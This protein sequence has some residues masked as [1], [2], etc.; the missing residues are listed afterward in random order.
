MR[1]KP[2]DPRLH[3]IEVTSK[4]I[5]AIQIAAMLFF[6]AYVALLNG[7]SISPLYIPL[8]NV[9]L[10]GS[11]LLLLVSAERLFFFRVSMRYTKRENPKFIFS[12]KSLSGSVSLIIVSVLLLALILLPYTSEL[13]MNGTAAGSPAIVQF[14]GSALF[15][16]A[17]ADTITVRNDGAGSLNFA[18][19]TPSSYQ[20]ATSSDGMNETVIMASSLLG[21]TPALQPGASY[22]FSVFLNPEDTYY[23]IFL[24]STGPAQAQYTI[25]YADNVTDMIAA[26]VVVAS[27]II[28]AFSASAA[29]KSMKELRGSTIYT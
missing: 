7:F 20:A 6:A 29:R 17:L 3:R 1:R 28:L 8:D 23:L 19:V 22:S 16:V 4:A 10:V 27:V 5:F 26:G 12:K 18:L 25:H 24:P 21:Q 14:K 13:N 15:T 11:I 9:L 2:L